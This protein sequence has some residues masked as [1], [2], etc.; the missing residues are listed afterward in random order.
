MSPGGAGAGYGGSC[1]PKDL[2]ALAQ[3]A[4]ACG[5]PATIVEA[6][7]TVNERQKRRL[8]ELICRHY[9][10]PRRLRDR[11]FA[12]W[13]LAFKPDTDDLRDATS[14][15]LVE[16]LIDAGA[17]VQAF[18]PQ[19]LRAAARLWR[20][21]SG[22]VA[23]DTA[24]HALDG[25]DALVLVTEWRDFLAPDFSRLRARL[26]DAA[27]FDGRNVYDMDAAAAAGLRYYGI[28][29]G[30]GARGDELHAVMSRLPDHAARPRERTTA[31]VSG[32]R[33]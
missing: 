3:T 28:G 33:V 24:D 9:G 7:E 10:G 8:F 2:R 5:R 4:R 26:Q 12:L 17:R 21:H 29:R 32:A 20:R 1:F 25:A 16:Q 13:G 30:C 27:V 19:A 15:V 23:C 31:L 22:F 6:V 18:D 11:T 14:L